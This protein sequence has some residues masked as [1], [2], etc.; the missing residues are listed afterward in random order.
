MG[1]HKS[2]KGLI[3]GLVAE[4]KKPAEILFPNGCPMRSCPIFKAGATHTCNGFMAESEIGNG[5]WECGVCGGHIYMPDPISW[6]YG[7]D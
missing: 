6:F 2:N 7:K 5:Q 3:D 1:R 4:L